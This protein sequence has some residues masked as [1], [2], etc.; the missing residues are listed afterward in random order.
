MS[1][2]WT[3]SA[4]LAR[5][6]RASLLPLAGAFEVASGLRRHAYRAGWLPR[7]RLPLPTVAVGNLAMGGAGKTPVAGWIAAWF[8]SRGVPAGVLLRG[9]GRDEAVLHREAAP[10][11]VVVEDPDR[12]RGAAVAAERGAQVLVLDDGFQHLRVAR[13]ADIV[14]VS[15]ESAAQPPWTLP[16]GPWREGWGQLRRA[17]LVVVTVKAAGP[18]AVAAAVGRVRRHAGDRPVAVARLALSGLTGLRTGARLPLDLL[19]GARILA[20]SGIADPAGFRRQLEQAGARVAARAW[21]DHHRYTGGDVAW[22]HR[23]AAKLDY[24]VVTAKDAPKLRPLWP[25]SAREALVARLSVEWE[26]GL[27]HLERLLG[28]CL[29]HHPR[30]AGAPPQPAAAGHPA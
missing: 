3:S 6:G 10:S 20:A 17:D 7:V 15:A 22:I 8:G 14:L 24:V 29:D 19:A 11:S 23:A 16:A 30:A 18:A 21:R 5:V 28:A 4:A 25:D 12:A 1:R 2:L 26:R 27:D 9:Y 13:D